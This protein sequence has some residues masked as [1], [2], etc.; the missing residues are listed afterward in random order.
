[1]KRQKMLVVEDDGVIALYLQTV[2]ARS[3]YEVLSSASTGL[4]AIAT[5]RES[6]P[7]L[8]LMGITLRGGMDGI[9][10]AAAIRTFSDVPII[11]LTAD[12][13]GPVR[14]RAKASAHEGYLVKPV[15]ER[16]LL[17]AAD[18]ALRQRDR[19]SAIAPEKGLPGV[20]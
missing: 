5:A 15:T 1:M 16:D 17:L 12:S 2:F 14:E 6:D 4:D 18:T 8:I 11:Y 7:G 19:V 3:G 9:A 20:S 10:A 13:E